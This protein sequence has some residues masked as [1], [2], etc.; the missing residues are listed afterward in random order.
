MGT[1]TTYKIIRTF[2][3][4]GREAFVRGGLALD[5]A[6]RFCALPINKAGRER[7]RRHGAWADHYEIENP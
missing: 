3:R 2:Y 5:E 6:K 4:N 1:V 7:T